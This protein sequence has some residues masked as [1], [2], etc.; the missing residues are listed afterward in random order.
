MADHPLTLGDRVEQ[1]RHGGSELWALGLDVPE[2][3]SFAGSI[4][5]GAD[6]GSSERLLLRFTAKMLDRGSARLDRFE[7]ADWLERRGAQLSFSSR[8]G[9]V[10]FRGRALREDVSDVMALAAEL[11]A[12]PRLD[13][14]DVE[15]VRRELDAGIREARADT[16]FLA[17]AALANHLYAPSHPGYRVDLD[18][19]ARAL[20]ATTRDDL[21]RFHEQHV[22]G[23]PVRLAVAGDLGGLGLGELLR[24]FPDA[25]APQGSPPPPVTVAAPGRSRVEVPDKPNLDVRLGHGIALTRH[26]AAFLPLMA[27]V[28]ALGGNFS[29][30]LMQEVRDRKGLTYGI[31]AGLEYIDRDQQGHFGIRATFSTADLEKGLA[32]TAEVFEQWADEG[33]GVDELASVRETLVGTYDVSL[34][35]T[36]GIA[37]RLLARAEQ[38]FSPAY[39]DTYREQLQG[40]ESATVTAAIRRHAHPA[41]VHV[42]TA[43]V[44]PVGVTGS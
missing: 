28:Y 18:E 12:T 40:L 9:Y 38:G 27:G 4:A 32:A 8:D 23:R 33:V 2:A 19:K 6:L 43:G 20:A 3:V 22:A 11:V 26:D 41:G 44:H 34:S 31:R 25:P 13:A 30:R 37:G 17:A 10:A 36:G 21:V 1:H 24:R 16:G 42:A 35:T 7:V 14:D 39:L 5:T 15:R 29:A